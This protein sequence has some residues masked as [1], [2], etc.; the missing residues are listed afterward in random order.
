LDVNGDKNVSS[1]DALMVINYL[2]NNTGEAE[3]S[4]GETGEGESIDSASD[5]SSHA[6]LEDELLSLL[7]TDSATSKQRTRVALS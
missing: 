1:I 6:L 3:G 4:S 2:N 7:A 5:G